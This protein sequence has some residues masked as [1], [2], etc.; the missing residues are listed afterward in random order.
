VSAS[1]PTLRRQPLVSGSERLHIAMVAPP[2]FAIP[3][4]GYGGVEAVVAD[5]VDALVERGH[6]ITLI[7]AGCH[8]TNAHEF[9][10]TY[11][12]PPAD[13]L[14][15]PL[16][17]VVHAA[18]VA[19][20]LDSV[21][22][23]VIHDHTLAG[24][25]LARGRLTPTV[26]TVHGPLNGEAGDYYAALGD[27][28]GLVAISHAQRSTSPH[29]SWLA[30]V[31]N[32]IQLDTFAFRADKEPFAL[33]LGRFHPHKAP[34]LAIDAAR[35][36]GL[37]IVLAG[38]CAEPI[39]RTYFAEHVA[40]RLGND[41]TIYGVANATAKRD[42]LSRAACL[43][44][45]ICW[46]EPFGLVLIE[47]M[48][49]GTPVAALRRGSVPEIVIDGHTGIL[50]EDPCDLADAI[51]RSGHLDPGDCRRH[52]ATH[53]TT[54][55]MASGYEAAYHQALSRATPPAKTMSQ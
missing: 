55:V 14:G 49:C 45:P 21:S 24:P 1:A 4:D 35:Q 34:H 12:T 25:L 2:Y 33:F 26:V 22:P 5:L 51:S 53:F 41:T 39:E 15:E 20:I 44:F 8:R 31:H 27:T 48:A 16:P 46:D 37:P 54:P 9:I 11:D 13:R 6:R 23:D 18:Q 52:V 19:A 43:V 50:V 7:G 17:E 40:P 36:A 47:A 32:S 10:A 3:P 38:K 30:T 28:V 29:L 42:L